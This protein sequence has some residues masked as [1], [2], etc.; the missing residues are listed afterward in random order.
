MDPIDIVYLLTEAN[1][2]AYGPYHAKC[3]MLTV[4]AFQCHADAEHPHPRE[5]QRKLPPD[6]PE[7]R[8]DARPSE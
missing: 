7:T 4:L 1:G 2:R 8:V 3:A 5:L 6:S